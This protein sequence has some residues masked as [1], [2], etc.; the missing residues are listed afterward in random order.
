M[1][2]L[3]LILCLFIAGCSFH[4]S[5]NEA[6]ST[7]FR[8][9]YF[10]QKEAQLS[11]E[12]LRAHPEIIV[13]QTFDELNKYA[14]QKIALWID[15]STTPFDSEEEEWINT[16]PQAYDPIVLI[17]TS[18]TLYAF[19]DLLRLHGFQGPAGNYPGYD[20]PGFS[21][22]QWKATNQP[23]DHEVVFLHGFNQKPTVPSILEITN[24]LLEGKVIATPTLVP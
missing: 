20:A 14:N 1:K 15:K 22:V 18:D 8:A 4:T 23:D 17:G 9:V 3:A 12:D 5:L 11:S 7:S 16:A 10:F 6:S 24:D 2:Q 13:V 21:V 19:R